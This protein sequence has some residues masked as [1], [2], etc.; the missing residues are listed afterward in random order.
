VE[1]T[2]ITQSRSWLPDPI[3]GIN[4]IALGSQDT[5]CY[6]PLYCG[7]VQ[8]PESFQKGDHYVLDRD[9]AR[10]AFDYVDYHT[11][12]AYS[13]AIE[14]VTKAREKWESAS[15]MKIQVMDNA[16][17]ELYEK[18]PGDAIG[19]ITDFCV[20]NAKSV[21]DAW[22]KLGDDLLV[23]YNHFRIYDP[24]TR[25]PGRIQTPDWWNKAVVEV[26][27][28]EPLSPPKPKPKA[29]KESNKK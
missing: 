10:W 12:V 15:F 3:G 28:L 4:W 26:D 7:I 19:F 22:W 14:D 18:N 5:S 29:K 20:N 13:Y 2:T 8:M 9:S 24:V 6:I 25:R 23:K 11:Q 1:Y 17:L 21:V 27:G 16:A